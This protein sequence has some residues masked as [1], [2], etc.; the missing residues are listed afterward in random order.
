MGAGI[1]VNPG[2]ENF[3]ADKTNEYY[4]DKS[5]LIR[6]TNALLGTG[7]CRIVVSRPRRFGKTSAVSMLEAYYS[8]GC[9]SRDLF[10]GLTIENDPSFEKHLNK[11]VVISVDIQGMYRDAIEDDRVRSFTSYISENINA[12]LAELY[13]EEVRGKEN[14]LS[15]SLRAIHKAHGTKFIILFDEWDVI[16]REEKCKATLKK[17]FTGFLVGLFQNARVSPCIALVYLT[18][19]LPIPKAE[20]QSGLNN[21]TEFTMVSPRQFAEFIG[22]TESEVDALC[23]RAKMPLPD[24]KAW[25]EGYPFGT[26][27]S[28]YCPDSVVKALRN[29]KCDGYWEATGSAQDLLAL[30][31]TVDSAFQQAVKDLLAGDS[32]SVTIDKKGFDLTDFGNLDTALTALVHLG[33][34]SYQD[35][36]VH[37]PNQEVAEEFLNTLA[38]AKNSPAYKVL[39]LSKELLQKTLL[40]DADGVAKILEE[41]HDLYSSVYSYNRENDLA[42]DIITS[43]KGF[44]DRGYSFHR[45]FPKG[46]GFADIVYLPRSGTPRTLTPIIIEL[47][48]DKTA[49]AALKQIKERRYNGLAHGY[50]SALLVGISYEKGRKKEVYKHHTC[51]IERVDNP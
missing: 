51:V 21:F 38:Q 26:V 9:D 27:G 6:L 31:N 36:K 5:G 29:Q 22:F 37:I 28:V 45:E 18:G 32:I 24:I 3:A 11:H 1:Y 47:K 20:S 34:L 46:K 14:S 40:E 16:Y 12:E 17:R 41:N 50:P 19:I 30:M 39:A 42:C 43:Y 23:C 8:S 4:V 33:Y 13:P 44:I 48:W 25:Y 35:G 10:R 2:F 7:D 49:E 15:R